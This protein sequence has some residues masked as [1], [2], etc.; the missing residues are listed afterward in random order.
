MNIESYF[1]N[2]Q[3]LDR[4]REEFERHFSK[5]HSY[6][7]VMMDLDLN[8]SR[9]YTVCNHKS[10]MSLLP[11]PLLIEFKK[12]MDEFIARVEHINTQYLSSSSY[13][14]YKSKCYEDGYKV[15]LTKKEFQNYLQR[16]DELQTLLQFLQER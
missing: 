8:M 9:V 16:K 11:P 15:E 14:E 4:F 10:L 12:Y 5:R 3:E 1:S 2:L 7:R 6:P 13:E